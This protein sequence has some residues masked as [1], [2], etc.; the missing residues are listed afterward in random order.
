MDRVVV[1]EAGSTDLTL[2]LES[3]V[4]SPVGRQRLDGHLKRKVKGAG[5]SERGRGVQEV[6]SGRHGEVKLY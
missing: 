6:V 1:H 2:V 3:T 5:D 4:N